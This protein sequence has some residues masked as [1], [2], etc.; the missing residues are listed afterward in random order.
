MNYDMAI[1][2][3]F[4]FYL[5]FRIGHSQI[6]DNIVFFFVFGLVTC[7]ISVARYLK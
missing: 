7:H 6:V 2:N 1:V 4:I 5:A 3:V